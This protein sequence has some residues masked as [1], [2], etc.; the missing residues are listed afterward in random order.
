[1]LLP[2][3]KLRK[4]IAEIALVSF[5]KGLQE[6]LRAAFKGDK[7]FEFRAVDGALSQF[8]SHFDPGSGPS[9]LIA[10]L[11]GD[12]PNAIAAFENL[13]RH[14]FDGSIVAIS[15][16]LDEHAVRGLLRLRITDWLPAS[17]PTQDIVQACERA[18]SVKKRPNRATPLECIA[19]VPAAGGV[20]NTTLAI[21]TGFLL[22][23]RD[24]NYES[25]CL[26]DLDFQSG[27]LADYLDLTPGFKVSSVADAPERLDGH[28][29]Q[30]MLSR[31]ETGMAVLA[32][33]RAPTECLHVDAAV[34]TKTLGVASE[35]FDNMVIDLPTSWQP[36]TDDV[37]AGSDRI[38]VVTEFTVPALRKAH[39]LVTALRNSLDKA[40]PIKVLVNKCRRQLFGSGLSKRDAAELLGDYLGGFVP[41]DYALVRE[42]IN[43][44]RPLSAANRSNR[45]SRELSRI[46]NPA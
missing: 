4:D 42:A 36:W 29:L 3:I 17:A 9:V 38:Y 22:A 34:V 21:Q 31:H 2:R 26:V 14:R 46:I 24:R 39:E 32:P 19:F 10:D 25:T 13:R 11:N 41:E 37:L 27:T 8:V 28:L 33:P 30:V 23:Q 6:R 43:R 18:L 40:A 12:P 45:V 16:T 15:D 7:R 20:G 1:M 35:M 5:N 44:G